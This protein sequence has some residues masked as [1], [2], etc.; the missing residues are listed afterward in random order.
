[1]GEVIEEKIESIEFGR[2]AAQTAKQVIVQKVREAERAQV[3]DAYREKV[4]EIISGTVKKVTRD[5]VIVD[6]GNNAEALLARDQIIPR[7][8]FRVGTRVRALRK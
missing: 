3:V 6:L 5:N 7:E 1:V 8:T 4:G 2:I